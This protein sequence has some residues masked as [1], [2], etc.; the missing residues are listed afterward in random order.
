MTRRFFRSMSKISFR[1]GR[2][3]LTITC[4]PVIFSFARCTCPSDAAASASSANSSYTSPSGRPSSSST[5]C[6]ARLVG[7][8]GTRSCS[9]SSSVM[10]GLL[11][12][13][14][15][16][17]N[18]WPILM[19]VGPSLSR[20]SLSQLASRSVRSSF[21]ASVNP[22]LYVNLSS[23]PTR[24]NTNANTNDQISIVRTNVPTDLR[25]SKFRGGSE[26]LASSFSSFVASFFA[27]AAFGSL[28]GAAAGAA[29][30]GAAAGVSDGRASSSAET[31]STL[32][33]SSCGKRS[34]G[35]QTGATSARDR[36]E[37]GDARANGRARERRRL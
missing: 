22:P 35:K 31:I 37:A 18:C 9:F 20:P 8:G 26:T 23:S 7:N 14:T 13:S 6:L 21:F 32:H 28:A 30:A 27:S 1:P 4:S 17:E 5:I 29:A 10:N 15:R 19:N 12:T 16:V 34:R 3:T 24:R 11:R 25:R 33:S 2:C 36:G